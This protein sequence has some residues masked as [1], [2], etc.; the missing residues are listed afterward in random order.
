MSSMLS[1]GSSDLERSTILEDDAIVAWWLL[2]EAD[3]VSVCNEGVESTER[4][5][6]RWGGKR[7]E[8]G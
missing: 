4:Q 5:T 6:R 8:R 2:L 3:I 7:E 1:T